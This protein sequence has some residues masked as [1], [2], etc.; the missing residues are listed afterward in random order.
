MGAA[1]LV[2][3][4]LVKT[5]LQEEYQNLQC[6]FRKLN[7]SQTTIIQVLQTIYGYCF[8]TL[9]VLHWAIVVLYNTQ[10]CIELK[11]PAQTSIVLES[12]VS[13]LPLCLNK[14]FA[15]KM[16]AQCCQL[17]RDLHNAL[18]INHEQIYPV[19]PE[20]CQFTVYSCEN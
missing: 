17:R 16:L 6:S 2:R 8:C 7:L 18:L 15:W 3:T 14:D 5:A 19:H 12:F 13:Q 20:I 9:L 11:A 4:M 1:M 10:W